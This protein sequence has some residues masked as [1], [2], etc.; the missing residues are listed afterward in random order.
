MSPPPDD[1]VD[2][3]E[4]RMSFMIPCFPVA[5]SEGSN[6]KRLTKQRSRSSSMET[7]ALRK[8]GSPLSAA[9]SGPVTEEAADEVVDV[10]FS[11][12]CRAKSPIL[13]HSAGSKNQMPKILS[14]FLYSKKWSSSG[15]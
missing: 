10:V 7:T 4:E 14:R 1:V 15:F 3:D 9:L 6:G 12:N 13:R 11:T 2:V 5:V 8:R